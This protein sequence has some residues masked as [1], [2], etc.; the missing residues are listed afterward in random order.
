MLLRRLNFGCNCRVNKLFDDFLR[1]VTGRF[2]PV[3]D[4]AIQSTTDVRPS[5]VEHIEK[6]NA[7]LIVTPC[8]H[9]PVV[10]F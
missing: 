9:R 6:I 7:R 10:V 5:K 1:V 8:M 3:G 2:L 4:D